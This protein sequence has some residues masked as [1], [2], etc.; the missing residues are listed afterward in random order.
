MINWIGTE[1]VCGARQGLNNLTQKVVSLKEE[2]TSATV[3]AEI[4]MGKD[5]K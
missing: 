4:L 2:K 3:R 5:R 1:P